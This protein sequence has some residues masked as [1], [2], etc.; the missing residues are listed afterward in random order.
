MGACALVGTSIVNAIHRIESACSP[1]ERC[2]ADEP[3]KSI[4]ATNASGA[5][6]QLPLALVNTHGSSTDSVFNEP[7]SI[8]DDMML[9]HVGK[10]SCH[11][12]LSVI[13]IDLSLSSSSFL[14][15]RIELAW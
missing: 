13:I 9:S 5:T 12:R 11:P 4:A 3:L 14:S 15:L 1:F 8:Q 10:T 7:S 2:S 6:K